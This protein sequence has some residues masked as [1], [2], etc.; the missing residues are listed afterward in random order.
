MARAR[1]TARADQLLFQYCGPDLDRDFSI[2]DR[3][4]RLNDDDRFAVLENQGHAVSDRRSHQ[5]HGILRRSWRRHDVVLQDQAEVDL[6]VSRDDRRGV[7]VERG[8][9]TR[10]GA[11]GRLVVRLRSY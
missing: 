8:R 9:A 11:R 3:I 10:A 7:D 6:T 5:T 2:A 4:A 1:T